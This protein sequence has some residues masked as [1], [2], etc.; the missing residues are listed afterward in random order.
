V[1]GE[2]QRDQVV[3][4]F[5]V[6]LRGVRDQQFGQHVVTLGEVGHGPPVGDLGVDRRIG[7]RLHPLKT[8]PWP[9]PVEC[10]VHPAHED[11]RAD[12]D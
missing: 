11:Q 1:A 5:L 9:N 12:L 6:G 10:G 2:Q 8:A 3:A 4:Q 7:G